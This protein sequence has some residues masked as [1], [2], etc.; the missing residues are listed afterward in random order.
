MDTQ[1]I[2]GSCLCGSVA[3][4][5]MPPFMFFQYCYC[6]RCRKN[7]GSAH[8]ANI[9]MESGQFTWLRGE[10]KAKVFRMPEARAFSTSFCTDCG[11]AL[12]WLTKNGKFYIVPAGGLNED[13]RAKP[14]RNIHWASRASWYVPEGDLP[15]FEEGS[16]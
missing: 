7:T 16:P 5:I 8:A 12:P 15:R 14:D 3:Y 9:L 1:A 10:E 4:E 11:S 2:G 13:P 6:S